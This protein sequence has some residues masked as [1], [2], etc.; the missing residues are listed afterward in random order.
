MTFTLDYN[1]VGDS[2]S[3]ADQQTTEIDPSEKFNPYQTIIENQE[4]KMSD[5]AKNMVKKD[6][7]SG[8]VL[9]V[10]QLN[11]SNDDLKAYDGTGMLNNMKT[12]HH[13]YK[14]S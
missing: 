13:Q 4:D 10:D 2:T 9:G 7:I 14:V 3:N 8:E 5:A 6:K 12:T 1:G 11:M